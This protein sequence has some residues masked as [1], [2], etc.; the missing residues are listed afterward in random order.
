MK[1]GLILFIGVFATLALSWAGVLLSA[2]NQFGSLTQYRDANEDTL[3]PV[4]LSGLADQGRAVYQDLGCATCHTQQV[5]RDGFGADIARNWGTRQ[6]V[7][8]DYIRDRTV[9]LGHVRLGPDLRNVGNRLGAGSKPEDYSNWFYQLLYAPQSVAP[10][11]NMPSYAYLFETRPVQNGQA[12]ASALKLGSRLVP[13]GYE[14]V[15]SARAQALVAYLRSLHDSYELPEAKPF[16]PEKKKEG[17][18]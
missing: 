4:A 8:R 1:N 12:S 7:A 14:V 3:H 9:H 13:A 16:V 10:G 17:A 5:R 15:P 11:T 18:H 2:H 6:S